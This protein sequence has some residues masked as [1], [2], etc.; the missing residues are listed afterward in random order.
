MTRVAA[1]QVTSTAN[2]QENLDKA[3]RYVEEAAS[4]GCSFVAFPE[5]FNYMPEKG[6]PRQPESLGGESTLFMQAL[7]KEHKIYILAGSMLISQE[8][9]LPQN[10]SFLIN[11]LGEVVLDYAKIH[12]FD[13]DIP[14]RVCYQESKMTCPGE[15]LVFA[16]TELGCVG[17][18]ICYDL[19]FPEL[20]RKLREE[21]ADIVVVPSAFTKTTGH[22]HWQVLL[23]AR[24]IENQVFVIAPNQYGEL[25]NGITAYGHSLIC[26]PWGNVLAKKEEGEGVIWADIDLSQ[27][28]KIREEMPVWQH[29]VNYKN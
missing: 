11:P 24:A 20:Y 28:Q 7:A 19:R 3:K 29:R 21:G 26:D 8:D 13:V 1:I 4:E 22:Y 2:R 6:K 27:L 18:S 16:Q 23:Q 14:G 15:A 10:R 9:G 25:P 12:L 5:L 17:A